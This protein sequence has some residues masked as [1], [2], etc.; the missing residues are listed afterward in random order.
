MVTLLL[1]TFQVERT[2]TTMDAEATTLQEA[3]FKS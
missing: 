2:T 3:V 1:G